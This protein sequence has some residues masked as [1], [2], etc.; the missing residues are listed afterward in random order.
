LQELNLLYDQDECGEF[1]HFYTRTIGT[2]FFEVVER[3]RGYDGYGAPN[4]PVRLASQYERRDGV[5]S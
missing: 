1:L 5:L 4:A 2:V 3:R